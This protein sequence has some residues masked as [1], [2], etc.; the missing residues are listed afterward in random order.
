MFFRFFKKLK[1][2]KDNRAYLKGYN[3]GYN[4]GKLDATLSRFTP[5]ELRQLIGLP[6]IDKEV[7]KL[8]IVPLYVS[9]ET[10]LP[11]CKEYG[12]KELAYL[13]GQELEKQGL[14]DYSIECNDCLGI[15]VQKATIKVV[16]S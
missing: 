1:N 6:L 4:A 10:P 2:R 9:M 12:R 11:G 13:I 14:I 5:N 15:W 16:R 7:K 3:L 8:D